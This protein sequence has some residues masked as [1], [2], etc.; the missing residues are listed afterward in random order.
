MKSQRTDRCKCG[1]FSGSKSHFHRKEERRKF[2]CDR[3][4]SIKQ[5]LR[6][7]EG[8]NLLILTH[9]FSSKVERKRKSQASLEKV[10]KLLMKN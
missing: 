5:I 10:N 7:I 1:L 9:K 8:R 6:N 4:N 3:N 2:I